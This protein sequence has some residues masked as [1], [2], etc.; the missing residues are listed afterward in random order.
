LSFLQGNYI[1]TTN[2]TER[3]IARICAQRISPVGI[4]VHT[5]DPA[6]RVKMMGNPRAGE[7]LAI[8]RRF[9]AAR[10]E[11]RCQ[12]VLCSNINDGAAL[13]DTLAALRE[14]YPSVTSISVVP[15][16]LT[17]HRDGL[18]PL[19]GYD[20]NGAKAVVA[21]VERFAAR[22]EREVG[23]PLAFL[24]DE[25]YFKA[26]LDVRAYDYYGDFP[27]LENG[28]G[29]VALFRREFKDALAKIKPR[30]AKHKQVA[31]LTGEA[32]APILTE[33]L[34]LFAARRPGAE[35][36]V[37]GVPNRFFGG[38][39][40]VAG[41]VT[42]ADIIA[43]VGDALPGVPLIIPSCMLR[44]GGDLFLDGESPASVAAKLGAEIL[45][46]ESDGAAL[47]EILDG[48]V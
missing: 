21:Q 38:S 2:L 23:T 35:I 41:L 30:K 22:C 13:D 15:V 46:C 34:N 14:L 16:G 37:T 32:F 33:L 18:A 19:T 40:D 42:G 31:L 44:H 48:M 26:G 47:A 17:A 25:F 20:E 3:D 29:M 27:Q 10:V 4:S 6:L 39:V 45:V 24:A 7:L 12:I 43:S 36:A 28:V 8:M 11:V 9:A 1:T 5:T